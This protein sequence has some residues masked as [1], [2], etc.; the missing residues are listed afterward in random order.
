MVLQR[1]ELSKLYWVENIIGFRIRILVRS[2]IIKW[3]FIQIPFAA[4]YGSCQIIKLFALYLFAALSNQ[5]FL[6]CK[7]VSS[8]RGKSNNI[9][10][11]SRPVYRVADRKCSNQFFYV[12]TNN[13]Q[14]RF[15]SFYPINLKWSGVSSNISHT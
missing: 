5:K 7:N 11:K 13:A 4:L 8:F 2:E 3:C 6:K 9:R 15:S 10:N 1:N 12:I 14:A